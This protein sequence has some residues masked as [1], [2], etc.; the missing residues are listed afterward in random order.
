MSQQGF[1]VEVEGM[2]K[3]IKQLKS[4][5]EKMKRSELLKILRSGS[6]PFVRSIQHEVAQIM[7]KAYSEGR[8]PTGNLYN[9]I[10]QITGKSH[11]Y[12]NI[13][14]G[15]KVQ[16]APGGYWNKRRY[17]GGR[18]RSGSRFKGYH[19][20]LVHY[21]TSN[22]RTRKGYGRG[23]AEGIP[24]MDKAYERSKTEVALS[25]TKAVAKYIDKIAKQTIK[26]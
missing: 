10:G 16:G 4:L 22:R 18:R 17:S 2:E 19:A 12:P 25:T 5:P 8:F 13:Q 23:A 26:P 20:H 1:S 3:L 6:R 9:S 24:F 14:I 11:E 15:A 7:E 21:G